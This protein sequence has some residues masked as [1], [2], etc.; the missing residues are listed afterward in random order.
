MKKAILTAMVALFM[1]GVAGCT[2]QPKLD[3]SSYDKMITS[4]D[5]MIKVA[6]PEAAEILDKAK[7]GWTGIGEQLFNRTKSNQNKALLETDGMTIDEYVNWARK[8]LSD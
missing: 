1:I 2:E 8:Q 6:D 3:T 4:L 5:K 7:Q